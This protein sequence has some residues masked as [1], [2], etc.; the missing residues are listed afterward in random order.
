MPSPTLCSV[1]TEFPAACCRVLPSIGEANHV[2]TS[3]LATSLLIE[4]L[5]KFRAKQIQKNDQNG[6]HRSRYR[7]IRD[8]PI[9]RTKRME[10]ID[11]K[12]AP[13]WSSWV[14]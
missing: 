2:S 7:W 6:F 1:A 3:L 13:G 9:K 4:K 8:T 10:G 5:S 11:W 14:P 12:I